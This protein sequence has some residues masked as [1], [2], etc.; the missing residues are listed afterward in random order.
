M[1]TLSTDDCY[2]ILEIPNTA[3]QNDIRQAYN[4]LSV[5]YHPSKNAKFNDKFIQISLAF[6]K[7]FKEDIYYTDEDGTDV[8]LTNDKLFNKNNNIGCDEMLPECKIN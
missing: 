4:K 2:K 6:E 1:S 8:I 7:L 3:S 5:K